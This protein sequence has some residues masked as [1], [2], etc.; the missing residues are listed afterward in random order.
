[1]GNSSSKSIDF[2]KNLYIIFDTYPNLDYRNGSQKNLL[3]QNIYYKTYMQK[4]IIRA[5]RRISDVKLIFPNYGLLII[6]KL[7]EKNNIIYYEI[8]VKIEFI[9]SNEKKAIELPNIS[10]SLMS[11]LNIPHINNEA[12]TFEL[13]QKTIHNIIDKDIRNRHNIKIDE[14]HFIELHNN[15]IKNMLIYQNHSS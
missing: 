5:F 13:I 11:N 8:N 4:L 15:F 14:L 1:M 7:D 9:V 3:E 12:L 2:K 10:S 6:N